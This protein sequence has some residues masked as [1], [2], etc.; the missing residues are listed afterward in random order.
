M[1]E[2]LLRQLAE[3]LATPPDD[4]FT[5]DWVAVPSAGMNRWLRL[6]LARRLGATTGTDGVRALE[7]RGTLAIGD[8]LQRL[9]LDHALVAQTCSRLAISETWL[10]CTR[11]R[12]H[13]SHAIEL[14]PGSG[15]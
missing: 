12:C 14:A 3:I 2:Q 13:T 1:L 15:R 5:P 4:P 11:V 9:T 10:S 6:E 7:A 8:A